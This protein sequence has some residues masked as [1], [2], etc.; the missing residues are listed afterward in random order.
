MFTAHCDTPLT[1]LAPSHTA[2]AF[3]QSPAMIAEV[4]AD[5]KSS[6]CEH[7]DVTITRRNICFRGRS[8]YS[9]S[10]VEVELHSQ[11]QQ[12]W[13]QQPYAGQRGGSGGGGSGGYVMA[14]GLTLRADSEQGMSA[15]FL[16]RHLLKMQKLCKEAS[17]LLLQMVGTSPCLYNIC[18]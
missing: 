8:R 13:Q 2:G 5:L 4:L 3:T 12:R 15:T 6:E 17:D 14:T 7:V 11:R 10:Q 16:V 18:L 1:L 9:G